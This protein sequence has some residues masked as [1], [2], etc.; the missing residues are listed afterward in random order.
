M[1]FFWYKKVRIQFIAK[2]P[3][4]LLWEYANGSKFGFI[5]SKDAFI[6]KNRTVL[7]SNRIQTFC[8]P[9]YYIFWILV[10]VLLTKWKQ[11]TWQNYCFWD[12]DRRRQIFGQIFLFIFGWKLL[13]FS[14]K[15]NLILWYNFL[16]IW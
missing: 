8:F 2:K 14:R 7:K 5:F 15:D 16:L 10:P 1:H 9:L 12:T 6:V 13:L 3:W 11:Q 4:V